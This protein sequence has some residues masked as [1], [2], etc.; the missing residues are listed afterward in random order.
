MSTI[1]D[2]LDTYWDHP[3]KVFV[4]L[5]RFVKLG[6]ILW[7]SFSNM[8]VTILNAFAFK[9]PIYISKIEILEALD[10]LNRE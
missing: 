10:H 6:W 7:S 9:A 8:K 4:V 1:L 2:L 3:Q 5:N